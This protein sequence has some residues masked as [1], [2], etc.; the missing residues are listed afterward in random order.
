MV[1][2]IED[3]IVDIPYVHFCGRKNKSETKDNVLKNTTN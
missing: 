3:T 1:E 2:S